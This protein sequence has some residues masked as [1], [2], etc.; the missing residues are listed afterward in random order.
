M[1]WRKTMPLQQDNRFL[2]FQEFC[3][4]IKPKLPIETMTERRCELPGEM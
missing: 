1:L 2:A 4:L 3:G